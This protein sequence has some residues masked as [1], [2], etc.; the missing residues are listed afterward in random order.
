MEPIF[1]ETL[2]AAITGYK[3]EE[4]QEENR[5]LVLANCVKLFLD[6]I[7]LW[8]EANYGKK[9][10]VRLKSGLMFNDGQIFVKFP[11]LN[12]IF[13]EAYSYFFQTTIKNLAV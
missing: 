2:V 13:K 3:L 9:E 1:E 7:F 4:I 5:V 8:V 11:E 10:M 12:Q 6:S